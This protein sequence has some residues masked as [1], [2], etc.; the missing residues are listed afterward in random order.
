MG[1]R[2][3]RRKGLRKRHRSVTLHQRSLIEQLNATVMDEEPNNIRTNKEIISKFTAKRRHKPKS[4]DQQPDQPSDNLLS[5]YISLG[6]NLAAGATQHT[7]PLQ[8]VLV[9]LSRDNTC[10][11]A[12]LIDTAN[13]HIT[14]LARIIVDPE[15]AQTPEVID[16]SI[17]PHF[18]AAIKSCLRMM[19]EVTAR[20][21]TIEATPPQDSCEVI[22]EELTQISEIIRITQIL[23]THIDYRMY[24][25][26][27]EAISEITDGLMIRMLEI[28]VDAAQ[29][30]AEDS[31]KKYCAKRS[32]KCQDFARCND[33]NQ[34]N[35]LNP[36]LS[37]EE[38]QNQYQQ[39][40]KQLKDHITNALKFLG[41]PTT[42]PLP[43]ELI[44]LPCELI[45]KIKGLTGEREVQV[46]TISADRRK[47]Y[48]KIKLALE[49]AL[50]TIALRHDISLLHSRP[51]PRSNIRL[52][53]TKKKCNPDILK[54]NKED[55]ISAENL[56]H[57]V[58]NRWIMDLN[59]KIE[60]IILGA[61]KNIT[62]SN[63]SLLSNAITSLHTIERE[64]T[65]D[66]DQIEI[67]IEK[68][69][70]L[71]KI[72]LAQDSI[73]IYII[74]ITELERMAPTLDGFWRINPTSKDF[75]YENTKTQA[76]TIINSC[77]SQLV[78]YQTHIDNNKI[79]KRLEIKLEDII[80]SCYLILTCSRN[81]L[82]FSTCKPQNIG[83]YIL[84]AIKETVSQAAVCNPPEDRKLNRVNVSHFN[85]MLKSLLIKINS[86][87]VSADIYFPL[88]RDTL[89]ILQDINGSESPYQQKLSKLKDALIRNTADKSTTMTLDK[90]NT[91]QNGAALLKQDLLALAPPSRNPALLDP[92]TKVIFICAQAARINYKVYSAVQEIENMTAKNHKIDADKNILQQTTKLVESYI[93]ALQLHPHKDQMSLHAL[94]RTLR[95]IE[96]CLC[97]IHAVI[98]R[99]SDD[100]YHSTNLFAT[101]A[102][103]AC[104][105]QQRSL[106]SYMR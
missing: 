92:K 106:T 76:I 55:I 87:E 15:I 60:D 98:Q 88:V 18:S 29:H 8:K 68:N 26:D 37:F 24:G 33:G 46:T 99:T 65:E 21:S 40:I 59:I 10:T 97:K 104:I 66:L 90:Y 44:D 16:N 43:C 103:P 77:S 38:I 11:Q 73:A 91:A 5:L 23:D 49:D 9:W 20:V 19:I 64:I 50:S 95:L 2:P 22:L 101:P 47:Q 83:D 42:I 28:F 93:S 75:K 6:F 78:F 100:D 81:A 14:L 56:F 3:D 74:V 69:I 12:Q 34:P 80:T 7:S 71:D 39:I 63:R 36:R 13:R 57:R 45:D 86:A 72:K 27:I 79:K 30:T 1:T 85:A 32:K 84:T 4:P 41:S 67:S 102:N 82:V 70:F 105:R 62:S 54:K 61:A 31:W 25:K 35:I 53:H 96:Q 51:T 89:D 52:H 94:Y 58:I 17:F 48:L